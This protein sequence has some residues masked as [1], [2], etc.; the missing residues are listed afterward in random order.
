MKKEKRE[1]K[2]SVFE[3]V[4]A[5]IGC[6]LI[7]LGGIIWIFAGFKISVAII[8]CTAAV[9]LAGPAVV[10]GGK[11]LEIITTILE[12]IVEGFLSLLDALCSIFNF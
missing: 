12:T 7:V 1:N 11:I 4:L 9:S 6:F 5:L 2:H 10:E 3:R 8:L